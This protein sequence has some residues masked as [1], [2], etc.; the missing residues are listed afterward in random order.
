MTSAPATYA[1]FERPIQECIEECSTCH[2]VCLLTSAYCLSQG[3][4]HVEPTH[5]ALLAD[6]ADI[7]QTTA[8]LLLRGSD[9]HAT[10]C[11]ACEAICRACERSCAAFSDD[12]N[13]RECA[14]ACRRC[15]D[16]CEKLASHT[17]HT[18]T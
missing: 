15:A 16:A 9:Q 11:A 12:S 3:G 1:Q 8:N 13:M 18:S 2:H 6:C 7:C 5:L 14:D 4:K 17:K 10:A